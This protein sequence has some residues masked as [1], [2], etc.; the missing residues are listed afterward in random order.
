MTVSE[1]VTLLTDYA[2]AAVSGWL[3]WKLY[4]RPERQLSRCCWAAGFI[5]LALAAFLGGS[6]HGFAQKLHPFLLAAA[7]KVTVYCVGVFGLAMLAGSIV[8]VSTGVMRR[9]LLGIAGLK[10]L[11]YSVVMFDRNAFEFVI[12]DTGGAMAGMLLLH[13]WNAL[14]WHDAASR[15]A[16]IALALSALGAGVQ[17]GRVAPHEYFNHNDL[18]HVIQIAAMV[19]FYKA[20]KLLR[21]AAK[22]P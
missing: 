4:A 9:A 18:Y 10:F 1:P 6:H 12:A 16:L 3:G 22:M 7:W 19:A 13:G 20:G 5:A 21:D 15:W 14:R 2:L 8:S 11:A 17:Y